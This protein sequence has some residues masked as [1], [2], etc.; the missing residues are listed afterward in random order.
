MLIQKYEIILIYT[1]EIEEYCLEKIVGAEV[2][3]LI[4]S[5]YCALNMLRYVIELCFL[6]Y[7][8]I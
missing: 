1:A 6:D 8:L 2:H 5:A 7:F 4:F 3:S